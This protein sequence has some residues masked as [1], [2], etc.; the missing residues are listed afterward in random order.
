MLINKDTS[1]YCSFSQTPGNNG[2]KF[3]NTKFQENNINAIYKSFYSDNIENSVKSVKTLGIKGFAI[4]MPFKTK[5]LEYVN[6]K[7]DAVCEIGAA[8]TIT[9]NNGHLKAYNTDWV[10]VYNYLDITQKQL[11]RGFKEPLLTILG[12]GGFSKAAQY[13]CNKLN[14]STNIIERD[15]WDL[16][17]QL[18]GI[19]FNCTPVEVYTKGILI[20]GRPST[21]DGKKIA[22]LQAKEQF[23]IYT[24]EP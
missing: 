3:F 17:P 6:E 2:C 7:D 22:S 11:F 1:I 18:K 10:G 15:K 12:N 8:N 9:N 16:V 24:N 23:K 20:D 4:S 19:I 21:P 14:I 13:A 5:V